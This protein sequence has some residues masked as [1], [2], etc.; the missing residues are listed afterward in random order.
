[1]QRVSRIAYREYCLLVLTIDWRARALRARSVTGG[2]L[3]DRIVEK[4]SYTEK[5]AS[6]LIRQVLE[7]TNYMH[8]MGVVHRDLKPENVRTHSNTPLYSTRTSYTYIAHLPTPPRLIQF[9][10][11][12]PKRALLTQVTSMLILASTPTPTPTTMATATRDTH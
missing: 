4:G 9:Q 12:N 5:D 6:M 10:Y 2:E 7:A 3:F 1:M 8:S 11:P